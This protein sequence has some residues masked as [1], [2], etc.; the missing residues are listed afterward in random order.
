MKRLILMFI[1]FVLYGCTDKSGIN[2]D[3]YFL[4]KLALDYPLQVTDDRDTLPSHYNFINLYAR[5]SEKQVTVIRLTSLMRLYDQSSKSVTFYEF[6]EKI[7]NQQRVLDNPKETSCF[8][9]VDSVTG[10]Y[11][12]LSF[13]E[14]IDLYFSKSLSDQYIL[15]QNVD[16]KTIDTI[17]YYCFINNYLIEFD[18]YIG[19]YH[20]YKISDI[21][22]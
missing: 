12:R 21:I 9:L 1:L 14:F 22:E 4:E 13:D 7:L 2:L 20:L 3:K 19:L 6:I 5:C 18:C 17:A 10:E 16:P 11:E 15:K 8:D